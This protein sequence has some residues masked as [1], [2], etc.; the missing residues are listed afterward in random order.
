MVWHLLQWL[1]HLHVHVHVHLHLQ[2]IPSAVC[3]CVSGQWWRGS[4]ASMQSRCIKKEPQGA[5]FLHRYTVIS[6]RDW[7]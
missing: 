4:G 2:I 7:H 3:A 5:L 1:L 6:Q